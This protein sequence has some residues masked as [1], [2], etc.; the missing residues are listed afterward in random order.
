MKKVA[1]AILAVSLF[2]LMA[3]CRK[4]PVPQNRQ[5]MERIPEAVRDSLISDEKSGFCMLDGLTLWGLS[6]GKLSPL[7]RLQIGEKLTLLGPSKKASFSGSLKK[8]VRVRRTSGIDGWVR[9]EYFA[10]NSILA[11]VVYDEV[12][13]FTLPT[14]R[15]QLA[16]HL[17][18]MSILAIRR[19]S[20]A[21]VFLRVTCYDQAS[22]TLYSDV[23]ARNEGISSQIG[24]V[25]SALLYRIASWTDNLK[26]KA[27]F[28]K[29]ALSDYPSS[30]FSDIIRQAAAALNAPPAQKIETEEFPVILIVSE[31]K[32]NVLSAPSEVSG[33]IVAT[34]LKGQR[35]HAEE[36]TRDSFQIG[37]L[38]APWYRISDPAGWVFGGGVE[39]E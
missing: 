19:D 12:P 7:S 29:S 22:D 36:R 4:Y 16:G 39:T 9:A 27:A 37:S 10:A 2:L 32:V 14:E 34:L 38:S 11:V 26:L 15:S 30:P 31:D 17:P 21:A 3:F 5:Q 18:I 35:I 28:L 24:S 20:A 23:F 13:V 8:I 1:A 25:E 33:S 6:D